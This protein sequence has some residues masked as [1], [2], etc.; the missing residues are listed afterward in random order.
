MPNRKRSLRK[1][2]TDYSNKKLQVQYEAKTENQVKVIRSFNEA[3]I[4]IICGDAGTGKTLLSIYWMCQQL[5][6]D[7][8]EQLVLTRPFVNS[9]KGLGFH[10]GTLDEKM[11]PYLTPFMDYF[12]RILGVTAFHRYMDYGRILIEP[13]EYMRGNTYDNSIMLL[14][15]AQNCTMTNLRMFI[16]RLGSESKLIVNGDTRQV[17]LYGREQSGLELVA[18]KLINIDGCSVV[19]LG[20]EF[21]LKNKPRCGQC[22]LKQ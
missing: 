9:G 16:S 7:K 12:E 15:E 19:R 11:A 2:V 6:Q 4:S 14:D 21:C 10:K 20:K 22:P 1:P 17:D 3:E 5:V 8:V 13:L 18:Q